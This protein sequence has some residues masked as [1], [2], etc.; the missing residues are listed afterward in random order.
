MPLKDYKRFMNFLAT[1][2][3]RAEFREFRNSTQESVDQVRTPL[4]LL[5]PPPERRAPGEPSTSEKSSGKLA[6]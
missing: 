1:H 3:C 6:S 4:L 5:P 2:E